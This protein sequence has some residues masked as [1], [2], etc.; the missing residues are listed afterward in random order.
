VICVDEKGP[1]AAKLYPPKGQW[2]SAFHRPHYPPDHG[3]RGYIWLFGALKPHTGE[4]FLFYG[5]RRDSINF[6]TFMD[7]VEQWIP[8]GDV[9]LVIDN[10]S[11]HASVQSLRW[12]FGHRRFYCHFLPTGAAWLNLIEGWWRFWATE[13]WT[14]ATSRLLRRWRRLS[15]PPLPSGMTT[16]P[17]SGG[18]LSSGILSAV[19]GVCAVLVFIVTIAMANMPSYLRNEALKSMLYS[20]LEGWPGNSYPPCRSQRAVCGGRGGR[21]GRAGVGDLRSG[22]LWCGLS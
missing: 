9:H 15:I 13:P 3:R 5:D 21:M 11:I 6:T 20:E 2:A 12:N 10:L 22:G 7:Q 8:Q 14:V 1:V 18:T 19:G 16:Q 17:H 4:G